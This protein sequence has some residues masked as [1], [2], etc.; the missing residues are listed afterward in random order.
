MTRTPAVPALRHRLA[1]LAILAILFLAVGAAGRAGAGS[2]V[3]DFY[4]GRRITLIVGFGPGGGYDTA[5]RLVA[6]HIGR[7]IPGNPTVVVQTM[8]GAGSI[9]AANYLYQTAPKDGTV[10]GA[11]GSDV[12]LIGLLGT[13]VG[14]DPRKFTWLGSSSSFANDAYVLLVRADAAAHSLAEARRPGGPPLVLGGTNEGTRDGDV[15]KILRDALG[16]N[17]RQVLGYP[18]SP[19]LFLAVERGEVEGRT[20]D[21]SSIKAA[22]PLWLRPNSG[23]HILLQF[24]RITRHPELAEVPTARELVSSEEARALIALAE[25]PLTGMARP[26]VAPPD[27][28]E[29]RASALQAAFLAAHR[30]PAFLAEAEK[31]GLDISPI[32]A[33]EVARAIERLAQAP[34]AVLDYMRH[35]LKP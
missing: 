11:I 12:A 3:G 10:F 23:F 32:G 25:A 20:F 33:A 1:S 8:A 35:L 15:P 5:A 24:A 30:D 31:Y 19:S 6:R 27:V 28:P 21:F 18:D 13:S 2:A 17:I 14:F 16:L 29:D 4:A 9:R 26:F 34:P 7:F 22:R